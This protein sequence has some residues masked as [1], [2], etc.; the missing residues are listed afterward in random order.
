M[1]FADTDAVGPRLTKPLTKPPGHACRAESVLR[2]SR[3]LSKGDLE[4]R[5][6]KTF[7]QKP[8]TPP[9]NFAIENRCLIPKND[10]GGDS[11]GTAPEGTIFVGTSSWSR[12]LLCVNFLEDTF[13]TT[14]HAKYD[15]HP[16]P[17]RNATKIDH[18]LQTCEERP[19]FYKK[20]TGGLRSESLQNS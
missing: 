6:K 17:E 13:F 14:Q 9:L 15:E 10:S 4:N 3:R 11:L 7:W 16:K 12:L 20:V 19:E 18:T 5:A 1:G 8:P 2:Y